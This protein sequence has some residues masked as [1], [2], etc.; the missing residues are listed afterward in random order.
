MTPALSTTTAGGC[1]MPRCKPGELAV[2]EGPKEWARGIVVTVTRQVADP[3]HVL[4]METL[5]RLYM[6]ARVGL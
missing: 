2:Y 5:A 4:A 3:S 1:A 6:Q